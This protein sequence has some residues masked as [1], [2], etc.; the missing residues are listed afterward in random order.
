MA[1][2]IDKFLKTIDNIKKK[3]QN[4]KLTRYEYIQIVAFNY[5][6]I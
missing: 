2:S 4:K 3:K 5:T 1:M 6:T